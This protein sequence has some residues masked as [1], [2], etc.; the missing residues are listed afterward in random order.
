MAVPSKLMSIVRNYFLDH[1][2]EEIP[3]SSLSLNP[4]SYLAFR[5]ANNILVVKV[6]DAEGLSL[7]KAKEIIENSIVSIL[8]ETVGTVDKA[9]LAL[10]TPSL[11]VLP[12]PSRFK[13]SGIGLLLIDDKDTI[14]EKIPP[15]PLRRLSIVYSEEKLSECIERLSKLEEGFREVKREISD[16]LYKRIENNTESIRNLE[17]I[18]EDIRHQIEK[19]EK[20][21]EHIYHQQIER[22]SS[23]EPPVHVPSSTT[24]ARSYVDE[25][26]PEFARDN[27]WIDTLSKRRQT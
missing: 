25:D 7:H 8:N 15:R 24:E 17:K 12:P 20:I 13:S 4:E 22:L 27:P 16:V 14:D 2:M 5:D 10:K 26:L 18:V 6:V 3:P 9:Y 1:G 21:V 11:S 23:T 19:M